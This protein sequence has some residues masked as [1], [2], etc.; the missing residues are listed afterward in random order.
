VPFLGTAVRGAEGD[1][2]LVDLMMNKYTINTED[3][4]DSITVYARI[5]AV[6]PKEIIAASLSIV[7]D[8][9]CEG[10]DCSSNA[11]YQMGDFEL[12]TEGCTAGKL[13]DGF[14]LDGIADCGDSTDGIYFATFEF[15]QYSPI[16]G[17]KICHIDINDEEG[18][19][20]F[21][22]TINNVDL[23]VTT[24]AGER[25]I[26]FTNTATTEDTQA[27]VI[28]DYVFDKESIDTTDSA[29]TLTMYARFS[30]NLTGVSDE[31]PPRIQFMPENDPGFAYPEIVEF[32]FT[33][34]KSG[35]DSLPTGLDVEG[36]DGCG[37]NKDGIY[38]ASVEIPRYSSGGLWNVVGVWNLSDLMRNSFDENG[39]EASF[40]NTSTVYD[41]DA[42]II[43]SI[44]I[45][46]SS[47]ET[48]D[49]PQTVTIE[50]QIEDDLAGVDLAKVSLANG[51]RS[52]TSVFDVY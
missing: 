25:D 27:P 20:S 16:G 49:G 17:W 34:M 21:N 11:L 50:M 3:S 4:S 18:A 1:P 30:D 38:E 2:V 29:K 43:N 52:V 51:I 41:T 24:E 44:S 19:T 48:V 26:S 39:L 5:Q 13:P 28:K 23:T 10:L 35:C 6:S 15:G 14:D 42:P 37:D 12:M 32:E 8:T 40:N 22:P 31:F 47:F 33:L 46:P 7:P 36:L 45:S 9:E